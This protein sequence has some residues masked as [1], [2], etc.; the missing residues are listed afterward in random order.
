MKTNEVPL[1]LPEARINQFAYALPESEIG[2]QFA[3]LLAL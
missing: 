3:A 1:D 2:Y